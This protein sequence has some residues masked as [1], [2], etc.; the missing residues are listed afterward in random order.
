MPEDLSVTLSKPGL[1]L[2][3]QVM[4]SI[5]AIFLLFSLAKNEEWS[6]RPGACRECSTPG[7]ALVS[8]TRVLLVLF[9]PWLPLTILCGGEPLI[10]EFLFLLGS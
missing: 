9:D 5:V 8:T 6:P 10:L 3:Y 1:K 7:C 4:G 2:L